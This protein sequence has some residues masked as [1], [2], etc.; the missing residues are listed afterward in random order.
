MERIVRIRMGRAQAQLQVRSATRT[1]VYALQF[2]RFERCAGIVG[3]R[4]EAHVLVQLI[5][6]RR[7]GDVRSVRCIIGGSVV[8]PELDAFGCGVDGDDVVTTQIS[9]T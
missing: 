1:H 2:A 9:I 6:R 8:D 7:A 3:E 4:Y 5:R